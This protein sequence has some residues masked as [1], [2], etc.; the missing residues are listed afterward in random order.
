VLPDHISYIK[1]FI[2]NVLNKLLSLG[3][4]EE[5]GGKKGTKGDKG[6]VEKGDRGEGRQ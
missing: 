5:G 6:K 2:I 3:K 1:F 4:G